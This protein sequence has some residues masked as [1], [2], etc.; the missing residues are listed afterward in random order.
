[1]SLDSLTSLSLCVQEFDLLSVVSYL[2]SIKTYGIPVVVQIFAIKK[3]G[4]I[5]SK[6]EE[7]LD[8]NTLKQANVS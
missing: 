8:K 7:V 5:H 2:E 4:V 3:H 1:M 6:E